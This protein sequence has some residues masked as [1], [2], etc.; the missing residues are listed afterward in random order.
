M[1]Q[2]L[3]NASTLFQG[4]ALM[5]CAIFMFSIMDAIAKG[6]TASYPAPM[7][8]WARYASQTLLAFLVL[9]PWLSKLL[10]TKY[11][12]L[13]LLRSSLLFGAT[14]FFFISFSRIPLGAAT[15]V[16][17]LAPLVI[18]ALSVF[19]LKETVG[20]RRW[21]GVLTGLI[22]ALII[23]RPGSDLFTWYAVLPCAAAFCYAG[24]TIATRFLGAEESHWTSFLYTALIG[25]VVASAFLPF[26]WTPIERPSDLIQMMAMGAVGG[27]G[28]LCIIL[29]L[30]RVQASVLAP[31]GY[32][33]IL[34]NTFWGY[35][36]FSEM[37]DRWAILGAL[38]I[39][40]AGLYVWQ[41]RR[42]AEL[43]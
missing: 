5:L 22:G 42:Q 14:I 28:H 26:V 10:R 18:T 32:F 38:V 35:A 31:F 17:Q 4:V 15:A 13:Q 8:V 25:T 7:V 40:G 11:P 20:L 37:P 21:A 6:L 29:A 3:A 41:R 36:L 16:F 43:S 27:V 34:F 30:M 1:F 2:K 9:A 23:I 19:I 33:T 12:G 24:Y 39:V